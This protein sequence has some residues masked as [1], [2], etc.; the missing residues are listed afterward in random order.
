MY[1]R[2]RTAGF[3]WEVK[4]RIMLGTYAL[5]A[6]YYDAYYLRAQKVRALIVADFERA[7]RDCDVIATPTSPSSPSRS[8]TRP[9]IRWRCTWPTST[10]SR[11]TSPACP[12]CRCRAASRKVY[13][14][15]CSSSATAR[16]GHA[17]PLCSAI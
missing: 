10:P 1:A 3:G 15:A 11:A 13:R 17:P 2:T 8:A 16:R 12:G 5:R 4:R 6:G 14:W 9:P 7:F